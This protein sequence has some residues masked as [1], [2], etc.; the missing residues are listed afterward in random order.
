[1]RIWHALG[2]GSGGCADVCAGTTIAAGIL[3]P[4]RVTG[5]F[6]SLPRSVPTAQAR[7][8]RSTNFLMA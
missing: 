2:V 3:T 1:L 6:L 4:R 8:S 7:P 5:R